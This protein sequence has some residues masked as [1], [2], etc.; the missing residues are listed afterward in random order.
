MELTST[1][2][3]MRAFSNDGVKYLLSADND[4]LRMND[5]LGRELVLSFMGEKFCDSC[6]NQFKSLYRMG[7][8]RECFFNS[9]MAGESIIRPELSRAHEGEED[10]DLQ[11]EKE[12]QLQPHIVYLA[13]SGGLKVGVTRANNKITRWID[14][15]ASR[16]IVF[17]ETSNRYEAGMIEVALKAHLA[18]K[19]NWQRMLKNEDPDLDLTAEK[20]RVA[21]ELDNPWQ[22]F[23]TADD[24]VTTLKY[25]VRNYPAKVKSLNL[26]KDPEIKAVLQGIRGQYLMFEG[27]FSLNVR[28]ATG[29]RV[30]IAF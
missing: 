27:G 19:T 4:F 3:K 16:A 30:K 10:R 9:P 7:F 22:K 24:E 1:L 17:A 5:M 20:E 14:Q 26:D 11:F 23:V 6:G 12:Y 18:D 21:Q 8:C 29:Y 25:P 28:G 13:I 2:R 15:G